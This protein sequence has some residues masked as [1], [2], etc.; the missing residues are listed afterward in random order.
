[1]MHMRI[2]TFLLK[3]NP[4]ELYNSAGTRVKLRKTSLS[5][6]Q[7]LASKPYQLVSREELLD[8]IWSNVAAADEGLSQ[9][10]R[11][12]RK[13]IQDDDKTVVQTEYKR[14][15]RLVPM[16]DQNHF[17]PPKLDF[18]EGVPF[19][20]H[21]N[22]KQRTGFTR[23]SDGVGIAYASSGAGPVVLR[24]PHWLSHLDWDWKCEICGPR[25]RALSQQLHHV[26]FDSRGTGR[27]D[28]HVNPGGLD[29]WAQDL[30]A[31]ANATGHQR[32][33]LMG[34]SG[35]APTIVKYAVNHP[36]RVSCLVFLGGF[37]RGA[38]RRGI[39]EDQ[40]YALAKLIETGWGNGNQSIRQIMSTQL[41]P[42]ATADQI[43]SFNHLQQ[44]SCDGET[45]ANIILNIADVDI[46]ELL[47]AIYQPVLIVHSRHDFRNPLREAELMA[48]KLPNATLCILDTKNHTPMSHE[49]EFD[50]M[51][52]TVTQFITEHS[53]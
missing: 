24:A 49:P 27:S 35:G 45:A 10:I 30:D 2:S 42:K 1:M 33:A 12:I 41:W 18:G 20:D 26:R 39:S 14:G 16:T 19:R 15:Y 34:I 6:L 53:S 43:A 52:D 17:P 44:I 31:V 28:R 22:F 36:E 51:I 23:S 50:R 9:C 40:V 8:K 32:F 38:L 11:D 47:S 7:V 21:P 46:T 48:S 37:A 29:E 13:T 4:V 5:V 25:I 3:G